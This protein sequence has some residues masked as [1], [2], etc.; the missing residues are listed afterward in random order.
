[1]KVTLFGAAREVERAHN[2]AAPAPLD[3][4]FSGA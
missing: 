2:R 3:A 1:M 4:S